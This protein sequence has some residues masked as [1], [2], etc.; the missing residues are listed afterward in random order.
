MIQ[1]INHKPQHLTKY[2]HPQWGSILGNEKEIRLAVL[3]DELEICEQRDT[4]H[5]TRDVLEKRI[6]ELNEG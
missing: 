1:N 3:Q 4:N 6:E 2:I 5:D